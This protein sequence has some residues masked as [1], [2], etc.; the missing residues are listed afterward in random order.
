M[1]RSRKPTSPALP[2]PKEV[3]EAAIDRVADDYLAFL[4]A[5]PR[6]EGTPDAKAFTA[7]HAAARAALAHLA[8]L[9]ALAATEASPETLAAAAEAVLEGARARIAEEG[10]A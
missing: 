8:E 5:T 6:G 10:K 1:K 7:H 4:A 2:V 3:L 9:C